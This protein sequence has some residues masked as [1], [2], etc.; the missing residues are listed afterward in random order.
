MFI[1]VGIKVVV[2]VWEVVAEYEEILRDRNGVLSFVLDCVNLACGCP[3]G[4][5]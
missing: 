2:S 3:S 1:Y 4:L 5:T